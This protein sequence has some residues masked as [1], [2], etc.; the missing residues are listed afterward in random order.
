MSNNNIIDI[1]KDNNNNNITNN[2]SGSI[3]RDRKKTE[4]V[5]PTRENYSILLKIYS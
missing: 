1:T 3:K 4:Y 2:I 5:M